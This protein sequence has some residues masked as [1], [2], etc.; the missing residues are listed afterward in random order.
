MPSN[1]EGT[2]AA[3]SRIVD[4]S[5]KK[6]L[7][8][9]SEDFERVV[10]DFTFV[11]KTPLIRD[12]IDSMY[13]TVLFCR[14]RRFGKSLAM[15]MLQCYFEAPVDGYVDDRT[16]LFDHLAIG[17]M[18][19]EYDR[20]R[21][22]HPVIYLSLGNVMGSSWEQARDIMDAAIAQEY[23]RHSY[24]GDSLDALDR[25]R[26]TRQRTAN[27]TEAEFVNSL[28]WLSEKLSRYHGSRTVV[29]IDEYDRPVSVGHLNGY[30]DEAVEFMR[31]W[32]T[33]AL[34]ATT[35]L[36]QA[37]LTGVQRI[38]RESIFSGL[39]N[40]VVN[41]SIDAEF[42]EGFGFTSD[43]AEA[44]ARYVGQGASIGEMRD[45]YDGYCF[46][47]VDVYNPWS[48]V[49]YLKSGGVAQ[50]Y[51]ANTSDNAIV[52]EL[53]LRADESTNSDLD[54]LAGGSTV[55]Q[56]LNLATAF[57]QIE[58][59][60][61]AIWSQLYLAGYVTTDDVGTPNMSTLERRLRI[62]NREVADLFLQQFRERS[63]SLAGD[64]GRLGELHS[65]MASG[66]EQ[67]LQDVLGDILADSSSFF[68]LR[69]ENSYHMLLLGLL[70]GMPG[71]KNPLSNREFGR[72]RPDIAIVP[73]DSE[74]RRLPGIVIELKRGVKSSSS[75]LAGWASEAIAQIGERE[76]CRLVATEAGCLK[77]GMAFSGKKLAVRCEKDAKLEA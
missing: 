32:L 31:S 15:R 19:E 41:T 69:D 28:A 42:T 13:G 26:F 48:V 18:G 16:R 64:A 36:F 38:S 65:A 60:G 54:A 25:D 40:I 35:S 75:R 10:Q 2:Q 63:I 30:R 3:D 17:A 67:S 24:I 49:N 39:N 44:L 9:G 51:W 46:G 23:A 68:D 33:S 7:P 74:R 52:R 57:D 77:W 55:T 21:G 50:P 5:G 20:H 22:A 45:W 37:C 62:P 1:T 29:I 11:D 43:E 53:F 34:K 71:Y 76:Y 56:P 4:L 47:G 14:P 12:L 27:A 8:I 66:D 6:R 59:E 58:S 73:I 61:A 70:F 72:G